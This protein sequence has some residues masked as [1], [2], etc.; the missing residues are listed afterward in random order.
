MSAFQLRLPYVVV[1]IDEA[2]V[3][4]SAEANQMQLSETIPR[5]NEL[6]RAVDSLCIWSR[7][8]FGNSRD[9]V[10][11][12]EN[13]CHYCFDMIVGVVYE[14]GAVLEEDG[15]HLQFERLMGWTSRWLLDCLIY[16]RFA[17]LTGAIEQFPTARKGQN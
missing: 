2:G 7:D 11:F 6:V 14:C 1:R 12:D 5:R 3:Y 17:A 13:V 16:L 10:A 9:L 8:V 4:R 15:R